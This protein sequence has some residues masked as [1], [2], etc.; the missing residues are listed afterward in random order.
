MSPFSFRVKHG[1][2][3]WV[4]DGK[5]PSRVQQINFAH[6]PVNRFSKRSIIAKTTNSGRSIQEN[7][8]DSLINTSATATS[9]KPGCVDSPPEW[10]LGTNSCG[11]PFP[12]INNYSC[13]LQ[14]YKLNYT[15][16]DTT[17]TITVYYNRCDEGTQSATSTNYKIS[18]NPIN[19]NC[20]INQNIAC[21][22]CKAGNSCNNGSLSTSSCN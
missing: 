6:E 19:P 18:K 15:P 11:C 4:N 7:Y 9:Q 8:L 2:K 12:I 16:G 10:N 20:F 1:N 14:S 13:G 5:Y 22:P 3:T 17:F 21:T